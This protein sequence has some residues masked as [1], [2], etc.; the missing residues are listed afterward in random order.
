[1]QVLEELISGTGQLACPLPLRF[2]Q[3]T[4]SVQGEAQQVHNQQHTGQGFF[5]MSKIMFESGTLFVSQ[6][7]EGFIFDLPASAC[8][9]HEFLDV[10]RVDIEVGHPG[11]AEG[12]FAVRF[13]DL[14]VE[15][16]DPWG[17]VPVAQRDV[18][19][20]T[21]G[22]DAQVFPGPVDH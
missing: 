18:L 8:A 2:D 15:P 1:M 12:D 5:P 22:R 6:H 4:Q 7:V 20:P 9:G 3:V 16:V 21:V 14:E 13:G 10:V 17:L 19:D 11:I